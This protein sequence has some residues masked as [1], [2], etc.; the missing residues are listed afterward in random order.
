MDTVKC[1]PMLSLDGPPTQARYYIP[2]Q[3]YCLTMLRTHK[4]EPCFACHSSYKPSLACLSLTAL[5]HGYQARSNLGSCV[6]LINASRALDVALVIHKA[7]CELNAAAL[8]HVLNGGQQRGVVRSLATDGM[9]RVRG[10]LVVVL[11]AVLAVC[12]WRGS[13]VHV[14]LA[15]NAGCVDSK[16]VVLLAQASVQVEPMGVGGVDSG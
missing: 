6:D 1:F 10:G 7:S 11:A 14:W 16:L 9:Q 13:C 5:H 3:L 15:V 8:E 2:A 4:P 12:W